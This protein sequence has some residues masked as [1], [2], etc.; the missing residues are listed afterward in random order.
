M[1][2]FQ[3][4]CPQCGKS[5]EADESMRGLVA[6][7]PHCEKG[8]VIPKVTRN[9]VQHQSDVVAKDNGGELKHENRDG[10]YDP[11]FLAIQRRMDEQAETARVASERIERIRK[12]NRK[13]EMVEKTVYALVAVVVCTV[14]FFWWKGWRDGRAAEA[15][16]LQAAREEQRRIDAERRAKDEAVRMA[17]AAQRKA[18]AEKRRQEKES[19]RKAEAEERERRRVEEAKRRAEEAQIRQERIAADKAEAQLREARRKQYDSVKESLFNMPMALWRNLAKDRRPGVAEGEFYC[20]VPKPNGDMMLYRI[21]A[22]SVSL[23]SQ[24]G[25]VES[26]QRDAYEAVVTERGCLLMA[27]GKAYVVSP[28]A[29]GDGLFPVPQTTVNP[30]ELS[31]RGIGDVIRRVGANADGLSFGVTY[32]SADRKNEVPVKSVAFG[33]SVARQDVLDAVTQHALKSFRPPKPATKA[34]RPTVV[35]YDGL[36]V[37]N[38]LNGVT[39]VPRTP[40]RKA[41]QK[42]YSLCDEAR[43][44]ERLEEE[45]RQSA[46]D[47]VR[48]ARARLANKIEDT[49]DAGRIKISVLAR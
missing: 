22:T 49:L 33:Q 46:T 42:Y 44:Q 21:D 45:A 24:D 26:V 39:Y 36:T 11:N 23:I 9:P 8:I 29:N 17:E 47:A 25:D 1:A 27:D 18:E 12:M 4:D 3:F 40:P 7:C 43:R 10:A 35:F 6:S 30:S 5:I 15:A 20:F 31:L 38:S 13:R 14:G 32:V 19:Q 41:N 2:E 16:K 28:K 34:K 37:K 48:E